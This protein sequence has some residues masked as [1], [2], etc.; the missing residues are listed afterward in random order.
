MKQALFLLPLL[1]SIPSLA[2][3]WHLNN[4]NQEEE[5]PFEYWFQFENADD[6]SSFE[7]KEN[8]QSQNTAVTIRSVRGDSVEFA[9]IRLININDDSECQ[10]ITDFYGASVFHLTDGKYSIDVDA[11]GY[12][13]FSFN[14]EIKHGRQ[15]ELDIILGLAAELEVYQIN[16]KARLEESEIVEIMECVRIN[17]Q[18][19]HQKCSELMKYLIF[20][21]A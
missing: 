11:M 5:Y 20:L 1:I 12:D 16:S 8:P 6:T 3:S 21:Q 9:S 7:L 15:V 4:V 14:F 13:D 19:F 17:R 18:D 2:Q 10:G